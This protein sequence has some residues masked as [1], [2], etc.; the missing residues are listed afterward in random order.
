[1]RLSRETNIL[2]NWLI[3]ELLPPALRDARWLMW[4]L[5]KMLFGARASL[6]F[7]FHR[8]VYAMS[9]EEFAALNRDVQPALINRPT[10]LNNA[11]IEF[12]QQ[13]IQGTEVLEAGCGKGFLSRLLC[14][15]YNL[16]AVDIA[17]P[18]ELKEQ[19]DFHTH[20]C[21][22]ESLPFPDQSFDTVL[23]THTLEHVR[24]IQKALGELRRVSRKQLIIVVPCERPYNYTFNL[25]VHFFPYDFM[26][27]AVTGV[28]PGQSL[29]KIGGDWMYIEARS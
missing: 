10:D 6:F 5:F 11:C 22:L 4:P 15:N 27:L 12:I 7:D 23:C 24:D 20:E 3:N 28:V 18:Q 17:L 14:K 16:T 29:Q 26:L 13:H 25:H 9:E 2:M 19:K 8:N 21:S 1:M